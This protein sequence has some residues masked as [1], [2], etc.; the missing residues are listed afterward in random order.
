MRARL[1][2]NRDVDIDECASQPCQNGGNCVDGVGTYTCQCGRLARASCDVPMS[3]GSYGHREVSAGRATDQV[4][5]SPAIEAVVPAGV[6]VQVNGVPTADPIS[7]SAQIDGS[8]AETF[9]AARRR[10]GDGRG[11]RRDRAGTRHVISPVYRFGPPGATFD[12]PPPCDARG[13]ERDDGAGDVAL[14]RRRR[15]LRTTKRI[16]FEDT[17]VSPPQSKLYIEID[18]FSTVV[19]TNRNLIGINYGTGPDM[20]GT[21]RSTTSGT[22]PCR[23]ALRASS[24][25]S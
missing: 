11:D 23:P 20:K 16:F 17:S 10:G 25:T 8:P 6:Q 12:P 5:S 18:H 19:I 21:R 2:T 14:R 15:Q 24:P 7:L 13:A 3:G 1:R 22:K 9:D 4:L